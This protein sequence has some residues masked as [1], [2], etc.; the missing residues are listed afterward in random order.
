[1]I[2]VCKRVADSTACIQV[3]E[4]STTEETG[5]VQ[6]KIQINVLS[7][8]LSNTAG[9]HSVNPRQDDLIP[10][11]GTTREQASTNKTVDLKADCQ[12]SHGP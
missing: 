8:Y 11:I 9:E 10:R 3:Y 12:S 1:M 2:N 5:S 6:K 4:R 7:K